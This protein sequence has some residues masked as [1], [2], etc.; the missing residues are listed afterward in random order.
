MQD[1]RHGFKRLSRP[2]EH[3][4]KEEILP[5][6]LQKIE[7]YFKALTRSSDAYFFI[8]DTRKSVTVLSENWVIDFG[9]PSRIVHD[10]EA[11]WIP[12]LHAADQA[13]VLPL[14]RFMLEERLKDD[15]DVEM[16]AR[17]RNDTYV[18]LRCRSTL[19]RNAEGEPY[20]LAGMMVR[21]DRLNEADAVTG[22]LNRASFARGVRDALDNFRQ[23][24]T[25]GAILLMGLDNFKIVNET[26]NRAFG[27]RVLQSAAAQITNI[28]PAGI[29]PYKM[30]GDEFGII[31]PGAGE[32]Q[33]QEIFR[34]IQTCMSRQQFIDGKMYF[35]TV[36]GGTVMYPQN[37]REYLGL[38]KYAE[39]ALSLA[40]RDGKNQNVIFSREQYNR[41]LRALT[42]RDT[43]KVSVENGCE[44]FS[45]FYQPQ[46]EAVSQALNGAEALLR[47]RNPQGRMVSPMEFVP[48]LEETKMILPLGKWIL[49]EALKT[50]KKWR[51]RIPAFRMSVNVSYTQIKDV[52]FLPFVFEVLERLA[53][54]PEAVALEL[55]ESMIVSDWSFLNQRFDEFR[56]RGIYIAMD[57]FGTGYS[58]LACLKNLSCDVVKLDRAFVRQILENEFDR[59]LV[60]YTVTLCHRMGMKV[61]IEGVEES[62]VYDIVT[63]ECRADYIQGYLFGRPVAE[64]DFVRQYI[65]GEAAVDE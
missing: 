47:W 36:S 33:V 63:H 62:S 23:T 8:T 16:R 52:T 11:V 32:E 5:P 21:M 39:A 43:I 53:L 14:R 45:L 19:L 41:W 4:Q 44:G 50:C 27:D 13:K 56:R 58:S 25:G 10:M 3:R 6:L 24:G 64:P 59:Q 7:F 55:T 9:L 49:E 54:P 46:V 57:D 51:E 35:C 18:W 28:L 2:G 38:Y 60:E 15:L 22:L 61:C 48:I 26:Y 31:L 30:D 20:F 65:E 42:M 17:D 40:K 1:R 34:E 29:T 12:R 37:G